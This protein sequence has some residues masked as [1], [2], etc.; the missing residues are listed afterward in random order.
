MAETTAAR[1]W[2]VLLGFTVGAHLLVSYWVVAYYAPLLPLLLA[3]ATAVSPRTRGFAIGAAAAGLGG[4][5][6]W[7]V[8]STLVQTF[9]DYVAAVR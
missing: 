4:V 2:P 9:I 3:L 8:Y 5:V 1:A 6:A 7:T